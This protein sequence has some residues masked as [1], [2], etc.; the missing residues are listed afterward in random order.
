M[1]RS[2]MEMLGQYLIIC[3]SCFIHPSFPLDTN[4]SDQHNEYILTVLPLDK[5]LS[6]YQISFVVL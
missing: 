3:H 6:A 4:L 1:S 2:Q 5:V